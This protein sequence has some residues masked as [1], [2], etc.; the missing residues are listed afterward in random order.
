M[1]DIKID[2]FQGPLSLLLRIIEKE[3]LDITSVSLA[4]IA[5]EYL[6]YIQNSQEILP[7]RMADFL[8][9]ASKLIYLKSKAL[10]P[11][12]F[13]PEDEEE[14]EDLEKQLKMYK[15]FVDLSN[16]IQKIIGKKKFSF[17]RIINKNNRR[18]SFLGDYFFPPKNVKKDDLYNSFLKVLE[19]NKNEEEKLEEE[20]IKSEISIDERISFIKNLIN[21]KIKINFTKILQE[22][23]SKTEIIVNFLAV[24]E[25]SKQRELVFNQVELFSEIYL[26]E[27]NEDLL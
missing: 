5:D 19:R 6:E 8:L 18:F 25:L 12:L 4:K 11:Y 9:M 15:D 22:A 3:E 14:V 1:I 16:K 27:N 20:T 23:R 24:L 7:E 17:S 10:L 2:Q 26:E 13:S 21:K